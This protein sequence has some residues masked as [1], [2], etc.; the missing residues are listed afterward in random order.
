MNGKMTL[1]LENLP[2]IAKHVLPNLEHHWGPILQSQIYPILA[3][4]LNLQAYALPHH[5]KQNE[6]IWQFMY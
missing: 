3:Q 1:K 5:V 2:Q 6:N 4:K